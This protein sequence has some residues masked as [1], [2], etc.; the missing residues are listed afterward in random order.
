MSER[1]APERS[2]GKSPSGRGTVGGGV[3]RPNVEGAG[4]PRKGAAGLQTFGQPPELDR[5]ELV[6]AGEDLVVAVAHEDPRAGE[7]PGAVHEMEPAHHAGPAA[8]AT[9][10]VHERLE[11]HAPPSRAPGQVAHV[12]LG[13]R[14]E[15]RSE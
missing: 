3:M 10:R 15:R 5:A 9:E 1:E 13:L 7:P 12:P 6:E 4:T 14:R 8:H 11:V 2:A